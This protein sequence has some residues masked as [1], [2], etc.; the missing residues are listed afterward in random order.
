MSIVS[1]K[2]D[3]YGH[4]VR[5]GLSQKEVD[6]LSML[7]VDVQGAP[8]TVLSGFYRTIQI[9]IE[10][11]DHWGGKKEACAWIALSIKRETRHTKKNKDLG[12]HINGDLVQ[13]IYTENGTWVADV[14]R[15]P[16]PEGVDFFF[17]AMERNYKLYAELLPNV[18]CD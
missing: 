3:A 11:S 16:D 4:Y 2:K 12:E 17:S 5:P 15:E 18:T 10:H 9:A 1:N 6:R 8:I 13:R 14:L 7:R